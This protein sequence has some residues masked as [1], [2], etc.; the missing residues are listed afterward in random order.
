MATLG[1]PQR[2][3]RGSESFLASC[4]QNEPIRRVL[5]SGSP[6]QSYEGNINGVIII[7]MISLLLFRYLPLIKHSHSSGMTPVADNAN[8]I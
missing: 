3:Y 2:M 5:A 7:L 6:E 1:S 4:V 8:S